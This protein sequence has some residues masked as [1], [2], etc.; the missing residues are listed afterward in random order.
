MDISPSEEEEDE[1]DYHT[2]GMMKREQEVIALDCREDF[3]FTFGK[4][5]RTSFITSFQNVPV[6]C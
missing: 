6:N 5:V 1:L 3:T 4:R 2:H